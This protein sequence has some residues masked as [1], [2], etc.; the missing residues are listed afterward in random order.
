MPTVWPTASDLM[1]ARPV[2]LPHDAPI[3][4][5][6]GLM[7]SRRIHEIPVL[8][9]SRLIG[10]V[11]LE[12]IARRSRWAFTTKVEHLVVL[13]PL[14]LPTTP[15]WEVA[16][17]LLSTGLRGVPVVGHRGELLGVIGRSDLVRAMPGLA[18]FRTGDGPTVEQVARSTGT[19][20][21][22]D[23]PCRALI[24][25]FRVLEDHPIPVVDRK[26]RVVGA[27]GVSDLG[28]VLWR[29]TVGGKRDARAGGSALEVKVSSIMRSPAITVPL[30]ASALEA[31]RT[32][33]REKV[34]SV[35]VVE[36]GR[37][38]R[39][40]GQA[41][42]LSFA[43][44][45]ARPGPTLGGIENVYVEITG[46]R[47][48]V[49]PGLLAEI[50]G[51]VAKGL[52]RIARYVRPT[53]LTLHFAPQGTHRTNDLTVEARLFTE[54]GRIFYAS[55]TGWNLMAGVVGL[56]DDLAAQAR[57]ASEAPRGRG[58][59]RGSSVELDEDVT[60]EDPDLEAKLRAVSGGGDDEE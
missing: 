58:R 1:S 51:G 8:R 53:L 54:Q 45:R 42:L 13:P 31:A 4:K 14:I 33:T 18:V 56:L 3:S 50:D 12:A 5:A 29:P 43:V 20:V 55:H 19:V 44:S 27:V 52:R 6:L 48:S 21:R 22:E 57:R 9:N 36:G 25:Q 15:F 16:E 59:R 23:E 40:V 30:G 26:G 37:P 7:R 24:T 46:L 17:Q 39:V 41:D 60:S 47:G 11:T 34:S 35:F 28:E 10:M 49:D 38:T 32:M 2:T